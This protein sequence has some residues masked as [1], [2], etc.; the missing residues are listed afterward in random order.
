PH[1][2]LAGRHLALRLG[3]AQFRTPGR[4]DAARP[5]HERLGV[6]LLLGGVAGPRGA[7]ARAG[8]GQAGG[9]MNTVDLATRRT[10]LKVG[11]AAAAGVWAPHI[12]NAQATGPAAF[13]TQPWLDE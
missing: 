7:H 12:A 10:L 5:R 9:S 3:A 4:R 6:R 13:T 8:A 11:G 1:R 2:R